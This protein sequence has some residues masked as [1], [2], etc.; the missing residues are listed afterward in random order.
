MTKILG[1]K[2]LRASTAALALIVTAGALAGCGD[3][4][5]DTAGSGSGGTAT[6]S[7]E[8]RPSADVQ[9]ADFAYDPN[10]VTVEAGGTVT[11]EN[12][13]SA[14]HT[15]SSDDGTP[16]EFDTGTLEQGDSGEVTLDDPG[17]YAYHCDFHATMT[18]TVEVVE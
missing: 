4:S 12:G 11:W 7:G 5:E 17:T 16:S 1:Q 6:T 10:P 14:P 3:D 13:D 15:A 2:W 18:A 8:A 9:V